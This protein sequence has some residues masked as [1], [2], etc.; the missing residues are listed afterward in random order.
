MEKAL[1]LD[2]LNDWN[3]WSKDLESGFVREDYLG[4]CLR[5]LEMD[6]VSA[7]I[8]VRR[9][10]KSFIMRQVIKRLIANGIERRAVLFINFEDRRFTDFYS[11]L[12]DEIFDVYRE[13]VYPAGVPYVFLD[14]V[15][16]LPGWERWV[17]SMHELGKAKI[18]VSGSSSRL[19]S[20]ELATVLTGRHLDVHV[21]PLVFSE[22]L[23]FKN[24]LP[25]DALEEA[26]KK[27][28]IKRALNEYIEYGGFPA[29]ILG[30]EK[31][32]L[33]LTYFEDI[34]TKDIER[35]YGLKKAQIL[36]SL[37][38]FYLTNISAPI[39]YNSLSKNFDTT[40]NTVEKYSQFLVEANMVFFVKRFSY[41][42]KE[43]DKSPRKVYSI[44][45]GLSNAVGF[46]LSPGMGRIA[47]NIVAL[48]LQEESA[49]N[50]GKE[51]YYWRDSDGREVDFLLK[52][53]THVKQ[54]IQVCW[55]LEDSQTK[56]R[57]ITGLVKASQVLKCNDCLIIT[58]EMEGCENIKGV[59]VKY[60]PLRKWLL[61][62]NFENN[63]R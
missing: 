54:L 5:Y 21:F 26:G 1:I 63:P 10:G 4:R 25:R 58:E 15:H 44:D 20:G 13:H 60:V 57:E 45:V 8:G 18:V 9:S 40:T 42:T 2:I 53:G 29:V 46:R 35:R 52:S 55:N 31:K 30:S 7:L 12:L 6:V 56:N 24:L 43:Q 23:R 27:N 14:E 3:F 47:E 51:I 28:D 50:P 36:R 59:P 32:E 34:L 17:R 48:E 41:K 33:L 16:L 11:G 39:T 19:L 37:A 38:R 61:K 49:T 62:S 22:F